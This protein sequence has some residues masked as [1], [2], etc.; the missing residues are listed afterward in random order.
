VIYTRM[1]YLIVPGL[2]DFT[3]CH[4]ILYRPRIGRLL[5]CATDWLF[6]LYAT[7]WHLC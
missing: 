1:Q 2:A 7:D 4:Y 3:I 6:L 5:L